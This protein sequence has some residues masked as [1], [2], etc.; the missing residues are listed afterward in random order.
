MAVHRIGTGPGFHP[1]LE[2]VWSRLSQG[3]TLQF[4]PGVHVVGDISL[5]SVS[6]IAMQPG[7]ASIRGNAVFDGNARIIGLSF[8][9]RINVSGVSTLEII[10]AQLRNPGG[11]LLVARNY[12]TAILRECD[13][14]ASGTTLPAFFAEGGSTIA[15]EDSRL[16]DIPFTGFEITEN[17]VLHL[18]DSHIANCG[19]RPVLISNGAKGFL[20]RTTMHATAKNGIS[21][22]KGG[23][24]QVRESTL[25][26]M[27]SA[28]AVTESS[29][30]WLIGSKIHDIRGNGIYANSKSQTHCTGSRF[31][32]T[33]LPAVGLIGTGTLGTLDQCGIDHCGN[34]GHASV[35]NEDGATLKITRTRISD[36]DKI[37]V[38]TQKDSEA[39]IRDCEL[40]RCTEGLLRAAGNVMV[41][42][43][44][45]VA[46]SLDAAITVEGRGEAHLRRCRLNDSPID[47]G[48]FGDRNPL[49]KLESL[50]G[51]SGVKDEVR[52]LIAFAEIQSVR[53]REGLA[54]SGTTL[55]MVFT[56]NPGTGKTTVARIIGE[57]YTRL[58]LLK[59]GHVVEVERADLVAGYVG[60]TATKTSEVIEKALDGV[61]F[62]DEAYSL[63]APSGDGP[64]FG[65]EAIDTLLRAMEGK[66]DRLA[67]VVAGYTSPMRHFIDANPGLQSRFTRYID[68][69]DYSV[70][71]LREILARMLAKDGLTPTPAAEVELTKAIDHMYRDR[72]EKFGNARNVRS[73]FEEIVQQQAR[74]IAST[75]EPDRAALQQITEA[76]VPQQ[77]TATVADVD[78]L[79]ARLDAMIGL[80][81]VKQEIHRLVDLV[82]LNERR[83]RDGQDPI[84]V[85]LHM[86][87]TGNPGTGKTTVARLLGEIFAGLGFL[88]RGHVVETERRSLVG[89]HVGETAIK[90]GEVIA[91]ALG[92]VLFIDEAYSLV[93]KSDGSSGPD[94][95]SE[96]ITVLLKAMEDK[97]SRLAVVVAGYT[98]PMRRFIEANP[99]LRSRFTRYVEFADYSAVELGQILSSM[100]HSHHLSTTPDADAAI[101]A[102]INDMYRNRDER[103]GN[104]REARKLFEALVQ[105]QARRLAGGTVAGQSSWDTITSEDVPGTERP[106]M[107]SDIDALLTRLDAMIGLA[108]VK[109]EVR[110]LVNLARLNERRVREGQSPIPV[111]LHMVFAGNPGTGKTTVATIVGEILAGLGLLARGHVVTTERGDL[112]AGYVGQTTAKTTEAIN[113]AL[114]GVL[115]IDEAYTLLNDGSQHSFGQEAI[116]TLLPAMEANR[117]RLAVVVAGYTDL[118]QAFIASNPGLRSR[119]T[120]QLNFADYTP[121]ELT[122]I[123]VRFCH[124]SGLELSLEA[125]DAVHRHFAELYAARSADFGNGRV[126]RTH[127]E[128]AIERQAERLVNDPSASTR[129]LTE[130]DV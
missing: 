67:V 3:D 22:S 86:V 74:R 49:Q 7:T 1:N 50:V 16:H 80:D 36:T 123:F 59:S 91:D 94:F 53:K 61:L 117:D 8:E 122:A 75:S 126:V 26:D 130:A 88:A 106:A 23:E 24:V 89:A 15:V 34:D 6:M 2:G 95:G 105:R 17:S 47:D 10:Q 99:G 97:R 12:S 107:V 41:R 32:G 73:L 102:V 78:A 114:D 56:G 111:S 30:A 90:T 77:R 38:A 33:A 65:R 43:T 29:L 118:M 125:H 85:S 83:R 108:E 101:A 128:Q 81:G 103:F 11:N 100:L 72:D 25:W 45:F 115:F 124:E 71:E 129:L 28:I 66:R 63:A 52:K 104:G 120:R 92:G 13:L 119:F 54:I 46:K 69:P 116:D 39:E 21:V 76:D 84:E 19:D 70:V 31:T 121:D 4:G 18:T 110:K 55:H 113:K 40:A 27:V 96:A 48:P 93:E 98:S 79:L 9:G 82:R 51:L 35:W 68:F 64:D 112:V 37:G 62:I 60:Q 5:H 109:A 20:T 44:T 57:V 58:G 87:F 127:F 14:T 42:D